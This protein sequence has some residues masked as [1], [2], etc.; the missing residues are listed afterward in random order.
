MFFLYF[1]R[2]QES[3]GVATSEGHN[4]F[5]VHKGM[6]LVRNVFNN[7]N[8]ARL[9]GNLGIGHIR[10]STKSSSEVIN[11]QPF[12]VHSMH[13]AVAVAH[14]GELVNCHSLREMVC[15]FVK[16]SYILNLESILLFITIISFFVFASF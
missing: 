5:H 15:N 16:T 13:G 7:E 11:C 10:Y 4:N 8:M 14:N 9:K 1:Y 3:A 12:L 2:G 6:G